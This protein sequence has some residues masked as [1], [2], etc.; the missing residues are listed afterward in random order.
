[1]VIDE[2]MAKRSHTKVIASHHDFTGQLKW[3]NVEWKTKY[4]QGVAINA[5]IVKLVGKAVDFND[6]LLLEKFR[7]ENTTKPLIGLNMGPKGK[8]S[9]VLNTVFTPVTHDLITD[10]PQG[11]GQLTF[12]E[13]NEAYFQIGGFI[14]NRFWVV[15]SPIEHSRSPAL[16]NAGYKALSLPYKFDR[17]ESSDAETVYKQL[18]LRS[19]FGGLAI[20]MPLK[21]DMMKYVTKLSDA[22]KLVG[23]IN[24]IV[25]IDGGGGF[26]GDNTDW[27]GI[28]NSFKQSG[29]IGGNNVNGLVVGGGGTSR[30][31]IYALHKLGCEKI[32][33][34]NRT[35][36]KLHDVAS[37]FPKEYN[38]EVVEQEEQVSGKP[39]SLAVSCVPSSAPLDETLLQRLELILDSN[40][41][42]TAAAAAA[43]E[44]APLLLEAAYKP[45]VTPVMRLAEE[46]YNWR[47][48][49]GVEMLVNQGEEQFKIHTGFA[50]PYDV[51]HDA[52]V[53]ED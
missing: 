42:T 26:L 3:D 46:K 25:P 23:A 11:V 51:I 29:F 41:P 13:I 20:T 35:V 40:K 8:L 10:K 50:P 30:A 39:V 53:A 16:H 18:M 45:R 52:V 1:D 44:E 22:A 21:L 9:R 48:I 37:S 14:E 15:G 32:Y 2:V 19:D 6:N 27:V 38:L 31:A 24:T 17:F 33:L 49:Q 12:K 43:D 28:T 5:D 36:S 4:D 34:L 7:S 47:V